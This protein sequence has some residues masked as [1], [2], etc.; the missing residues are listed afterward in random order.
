M[1]YDEAI[2]IQNVAVT[3][4]SFWDKK[5]YKGKVLSMLRGALLRESTLKCVI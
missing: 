3:T 1:P 2:K 5:K 4:V